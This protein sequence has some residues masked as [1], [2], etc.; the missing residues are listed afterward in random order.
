[1]VG[2]YLETGRGG[3][4]LPASRSELSARLGLGGGWAELADLRKG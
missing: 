2:P 4:A 3:A 1:M